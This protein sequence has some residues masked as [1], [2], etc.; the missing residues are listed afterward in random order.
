MVHGAAQGIDCEMSHG[1]MCFYMTARH[2][3]VAR[4]ELTKPNLEACI[5]YLRRY[6]FAGKDYQYLYKR[7]ITHSQPSKMILY[8]TFVKTY[9]L[10]DHLE[11]Y[12]M[13]KLAAKSTVSNVSIPTLQLDTNT[14]SMIVFSPKVLFDAV[15]E[16]CKYFNSINIKSIRCARSADSAK[17]ADCTEPI[18]NKE[19]I[20][21][22][23]DLKTKI[24]HTIDDVLTAETCM[25]KIKTLLHHEMEV[26][27]YIYAVEEFQAKEITVMNKLS[28]SVKSMLSDL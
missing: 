26:A 15:T 12:L 7:I 13:L 19:V 23:I 18:Q 8:Y 16:M 21:P 11:E 24:P 4:F 20:P 17:N 6:D 27:K 14:A 3:D 9:E 5:E 22:T 25:E 28:T 10:L 1:D 2:M